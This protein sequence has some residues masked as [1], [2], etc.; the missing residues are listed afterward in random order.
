MNSDEQLELLTA[1]VSL[2][3][4]GRAATQLVHRSLAAVERRLLD[5]VGPLVRKRVAAQLLGVSVQAL[6]RWSGRGDI[7]T[8]AIREGSS[9]HAIPTD[10]LVALAC[11]VRIAQRD[12][13]VGQPLH[14][15]VMALRRRRHLAREA[16]N[17]HNLIVAGGTIMAAARRARSSS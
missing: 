11:E 6:D 9:R 10:E 17:A 12:G 4:E 3:V 14:T 13:D 2:R 15:A 7:A 8:A 1:A 16:R 5:L